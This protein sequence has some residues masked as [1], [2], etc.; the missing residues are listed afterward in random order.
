MHLVLFIIQANKCTTYVYQQNFIYHKYSYTL[1]GTTSTSTAGLNWTPYDTHIT[2]DMLPQHQ[3][4]I[5]K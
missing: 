4:N 2:H 5:T 1:Y 3:I